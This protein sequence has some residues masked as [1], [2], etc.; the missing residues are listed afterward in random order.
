MKEIQNAETEL[1]NRIKQFE[2]RKKREEQNELQVNE[3]RNACLNALGVPDP[4]HSKTRI[5]RDKGGLVPNCCDWIRPQ[6]TPEQGIFLDWLE[7][8]EQSILW[9]TGKAGKGKTM[10]MCDLIQWLE[11]TNN[12]KQIFYFFCEISKSQTT[13]YNAAAIRGLI[14]TIVSEAKQLT[15]YIQ[16]EWEKNNN[17]F[18]DANVQITSYEILKAILSD[19]LLSGATIFVDALD[20]C[21][22]DLD[23]L[24]EIIKNTPNIKWVTSSR[25]NTNS[26][27]EKLIN[28]PRCQNISLDDLGD[29]VSA[30]VTLYIKKQVQDLK[31]M[32]RYEDEKCHEIEVFLTTHSEGRFYGLP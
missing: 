1:D 6:Q 8:P 7:N 18:K 5:L 13:D 15:R 16:S 29:L 3:V 11:E 4:R 25:S 2:K 17:L 10:L 27:D 21:G 20:E 22:A 26:V 23:L 32:K 31:K 24:L 30:A 28:I 12:K 9:I 14:Y 19:D